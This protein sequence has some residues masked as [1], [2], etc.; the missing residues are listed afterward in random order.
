MDDLEHKELKAL[1]SLGFS[2]DVRVA[3][4]QVMA[5]ERIADALEDLETHLANL[6][7]FADER[8]QRQSGG[9]GRG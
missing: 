5:L 7:Y 1:T 8:D 3:A 2:P 4:L 6:A 9:H